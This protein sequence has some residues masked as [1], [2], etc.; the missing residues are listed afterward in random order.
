MP[1]DVRVADAVERN[2]V[3]N[4]AP[5]SWRPYLRLSRVD[6]PIGSWL[7][8]LP[9]WWGLALSAVADPGGFRVDDIWI[10]SA[11]AIGA[12]LMRGA[13]C[14]WND[15]NDRAFDAQVERTRSRPLPSGQVSPRRALIWMCI[16][17]ALAFGVLLTLNGLAI[18]VGICSLLPVAIYP[19][20][21]RFTW[22]PQFFLGIAF[23]WGVLLAWAAH[24]GTLGPATFLLYASGIAWT[25][26]YDTVYA[27]QDTRDDS[28]I[29]IKSTARLFG[30]RSRSSLQACVF[31]SVF[32]ML[33][34]CGLVLAGSPGLVT[35]LFLTSGCVFFG[36]SML[37]QLRKI[38]LGDPRTCL[39]AFR[40]SRNIGLIPVVFFALA[41]PW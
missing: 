36:L 2:W 16:Q 41:V 35:M 15:Y 13:G 40:Q 10:A 21:K 32:L 29:G 5:L 30:R 11:C 7:L 20:A 31:A 22:W 18:I 37:L 24:S 25:L 8:L 4:H 1:D 14:T 17:A 3:D 34:A 28:I 38:E 6:R 33:A 27:H 26:Y 23:N 9:C 19:F 39:A 12:V